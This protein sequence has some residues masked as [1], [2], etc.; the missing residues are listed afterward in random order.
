MLLT[1]VPASSAANEVV[2]EAFGIND[3]SMSTL[4]ATQAT[5]SFGTPVLGANDDLWNTTMT[6]SV[7]QS[8]IPGDPRSHA[9]GEGR[10]LWDED[11]LYVRVVVTDE[12]VYESSVASNHYMYDSVEFFVGPGA[13]G[14]NQWRI[15]AG[16]SLSGQ[17]A[18]GRDS[19]TEITETG[20][21]V[22]MKIPKRELTFAS[23]AL[24]TFEIGMNN[25]TAA[26]NDRYEVVSW[27]GEPDRGYSSH[28]G[29]TDSLKL[30][31]GEGV[32]RHLIKASAG[33]N[34]TIA[35]S[36]LVRV[37]AGNSQEFVFIPAP[38]Y[39]VD[40]LTVNGQTES[41][42]GNSYTFTNVATSEQEIHVTFKPDPGASVFDFT[43]WND[44]FATGEFTTAVI[45]DLGEGEEIQSSELNKSMFSVTG[46]NMRGS[47]VAFN[48]TRKIKRVYANSEPKVLGYL[49]EVRN[50]PDYQA[51]L[52]KGR[53][54]VIE[55]EWTQG[56]GIGTLANSNSTKQHYSVSVTQS[57]NLVS[58]GAIDKAVFVQKEVVNPLI[59]QFEAGP[60]IDGASLGY[61]RYLHKDTNGNPQKGLPLYVYTH[62]M[63]RGGENPD[64]DLFS[65]LR[66]ANGAIALMQRIEKNPEK[67]ASHILALRYT[68]TSV[69]APATIKKYIDELVEQ[70]WVDP[71]RIYAAGF[72]WGGQYTNRLINEIPGLFAAAMPLA[73]VSGFPTVTNAEANA[74]LAYWMFVNEYNTGTNNNYVNNLN[75]FVSTAMPSYDNARVTLFK[76]TNDA[77]LWPYDQWPKSAEPLQD[78]VGHE[79][80]AAVL[81]NKIDEPSNSWNIKPTAQSAKLGNWNDDYSDVFEWM[82]DQSKGPGEPKITVIY[83]MQNDNAVKGKAEDTV[84][85]A[86]DG[87]QLNG[88]PTVTV[89]DGDGGKKSLLVTGR[90][91]NYF[92]V[93]IKGSL[94]TDLD[95]KY[96]I[97]VKGHLPAGVSTSNAILQ[98]TGDKTDEGQ[99]YAWLVNKAVAAGD[100]FELTMTKSINEIINENGKD[101]ARLQIQLQ[102]SDKD[103]YIDDIIITIEETGNG[104]NVVLFYENFEDYKDTFVKDGD[105]AD[106]AVSADVASNGTRSL[107]VDSPSSS[108][109]YAGVV[110]NNDKLNAPGM[111][112]TG[113][114]RFT[115]QVYAA[116][117]ETGTP[118]IGI[119][120]D[121][122]TNGSDSWGGIFSQRFNLTRGQWTSIS[123]DFE[124]PEN[125]ELV[126]RIA[127]INAAR[128]TELKYY[129][130]D[131]KLEVL[132]EPVP[133]VP[134]EWESGL[135]SLY[136]AYEDDFLFGNIM[137]PGTLDNTGTL[138]MYKHHYNAVS[139]ENA[140]KPE[141]LVNNNREYNFENA[142]RL[143]DWALTNDIKVHG[144]TLV[145]HAQS[146]SWLTRDD[147]GQPLTRAEA[148][149]NLEEYINTVAGH[150][151]GKVIS[152]DVVNE[153]VSGGSNSPWK[154]AYAN[155]A[156]IAQGEEGDDY[157][158]DA[159]VF[160]RLADPGATLYY[161]DFNEHLSPNRQQIYNM[162]K[163]YN[164]RWKEDVRNTDQDRLLIEG[165]G[166]QAH[167]WTGESSSLIDNVTTAIDLYRTLGV[168]ISV[169]E[170]DIPAGNAGTTKTATDAEKKTQAILYAQLFEL[171][172]KN[173]DIIERVTLW[174]REDASSWRGGNNGDA[175]PL[176][177]DNKLQS[178][179]AFQA[180]VDPVKFL[181]N[182]ELPEVYVPPTAYAVYGTPDLGK[183]DPAW[184]TAPVIIANKQAV[185][186]ANA[187][188]K[189]K[190]LWDEQNI[191]VR[192]EVTDNQIDVSSANAWERDSVEVFLSET[193][194]RGSY[195]GTEGNQYRVDA[196]GGTS[197]K[198]NV[199]GWGIDSGE[200]YSFAERTSYG[201][202]VEMKLPWRA[203]AAPAEDMVVGFD[204]QINDPPPAASRPQVTWSDPEANSYNS[205]LNWGNLKLAGQQSSSYTVT[206]VN[207]TGSGDYNLGEP[208]QITAT[209]RSGKTFVRWDINPDVT[210][211]AGSNTSETATFT[212]PANNVTATAVFKD[213]GGST[214]PTSSQPS[215]STPSTPSEPSTPTRDLIT[216]NDISS[217]I[218][219]ANGQVGAVV[220]ANQ[221]NKVIDSKSELVITNGRY[222]ASFAAGQLKEWGL[223]EDSKVTLI[224]APSDVI[225][226]DNT[227][228]KLVKTDKVNETL[229]KEVYEINI[230]TDGQTVG[231]TK[232]PTKVTINVSDLNLTDEQKAN[233]TG[234]IFDEQTQSYRQL[235]GEFSPDG[236]TFEFYTY[237]TGTHGVIVSD[238]LYKINFK[239]GDQAFAK[240]GEQMDNDVA[241]YIAGGRTMMSLRAVAEALDASVSWTAATRTV[242]IAKGGVTLRLV[243]DEPLPDGM[244]SATL[245]PAGRTFVPLRY[246]SE[247]LGAN[248]VW[249]AKNK[250]VNIYM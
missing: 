134:L 83:D 57:F 215:T 213:S 176:H 82:Y 137:E 164:D 7:D 239:I 162:V 142:D 173:A 104:D 12:D 13:S 92:G 1:P 193:N 55:F 199:T 117:P 61:T 192:V 90:T 243:I 30:I 157:F 110:L 167:Y 15:N 35:P 240:N 101:F 181:E 209:R 207:G 39:I 223:K 248:V 119:R 205:S 166:M 45:I 47:D 196:D 159:Y 143:V 5:A 222:Q 115:A 94:F 75:S 187:T 234:I 169:S 8:T 3:G 33:D 127:F 72:S 161:N 120:V 34:G 149:A 21:I 98:A 50:S 242:V 165:I 103:F 79:V 171:Y 10:V 31:G 206:V 121:S 28:S 220:E 128:Q 217:G 129:I 114:Y 38:N 235:G 105:V 190:V 136:E 195:S 203:A 97:T 41:V 118:T 231:K 64:L 73:P 163:K 210:F 102:E 68:G 188:G 29:F 85:T 53:Y 219:I 249:D 112:P 76:N 244:G 236:K 100:S 211:T 144:H 216:P 178:K 133:V 228:N 189:V 111:Q 191:Y 42:T 87:L 180:I 78:Y 140:M 241:P 204:I 183:N 153:A 246:I 44:N 2:D 60:A 225:I 185:D 58:G 250:A 175:S 108:Q 208:V 200:G 20:Y 6:L 43:V 221:L 212:M 66:S 99:Y 184:V 146:P 36:G 24:I 198:T 147:S 107:L 62:G 141:S 46:K 197:Q 96:T 150:Y 218:T 124:V 182:T 9:T 227:V 247:N 67:Y 132:R 138:E 37:G 77:F 109:D 95:E 23:D 202:L 145:W 19:W 232:T 51:G 70:G 131:V 160:A 214:G 59:D 174:G 186:N 54:I 172:K 71:N 18:G 201:Y 125:H 4:S 16:G 25:S 179:P 230:K 130:D 63:S 154:Q 158:Y 88:S 32:V 26:G 89:K 194:F 139:A 113:K 156:D 93:D 238:N 22:E 49:G 148:K 224:F 123:F 14:A 122:T 69:P 177:F 81:Y 135:P 151:K 84:V 80:E 56:G 152:W 40:E 17:T 48:E 74:Q 229:L 27:Y 170:L 11:F 65:P 116:G 245:S 52:D 155:G 168:K 91:Q 126:K 233:F 237:E 86:F 226:K 106:V